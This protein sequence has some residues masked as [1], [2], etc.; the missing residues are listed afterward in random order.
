MK[1]LIL[2]VLA[3]GAFAFTEQMMSLEELA[4]FNVKTMDCSRSDQFSF[5][6]K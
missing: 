6:E 2:L 1:A 4:N 3:L 5:V